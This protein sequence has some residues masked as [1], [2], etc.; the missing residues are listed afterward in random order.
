MVWIFLKGK[1]GSRNTAVVLWGGERY[2]VFSFSYD[3]FR[4]KGSWFGVVL[5]ISSRFLFLDFCFFCFS[6]RL[7]FFPL[8]F[9]G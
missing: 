1:S 4:K 7:W 3:G 8:S 9:L 2:R 5:F 6:S